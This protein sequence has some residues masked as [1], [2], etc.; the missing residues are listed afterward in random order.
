MEATNKKDFE[1]VQLL[2]DAGADPNA[3]DDQPEFEVYPDHEPRM[4]LLIAAKS[5]NE[6]M[7]RLLLRNGKSI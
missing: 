3:T 5:K 1:T 4:P 7:V 6:T 2:L